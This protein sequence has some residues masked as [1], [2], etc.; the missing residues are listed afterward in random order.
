VGVLGPRF[1]RAAS[2]DPLKYAKFERERRFL[3]APRALPDLSADFARFEDLYL[4]RTQVRLRVMTEQPA[5][6]V[7][8]KLTQKIQEPD[9]CVRHITTLYLSADEFGVFAGLPG[10]RLAKRRHRASS[11]GLEWGVDVFEGAL[12]G[13]V[14][15]EREFDSDAELRAAAPPTFAALEVTDDAAFAGGA[16]AAT[17]PARTLAHAASLLAGTGAR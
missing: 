17:D 10:A 14:L 15:A 12:A 6:R 13:L 16:L 8:Y 2:H 7:L 1:E 11:G 9:P 5:G 4:A 3:V